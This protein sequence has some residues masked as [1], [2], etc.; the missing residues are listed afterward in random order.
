MNGNGSDVTQ[1]EI[2]KDM[3]GNSS[4]NDSGVMARIFGTFL[5]WRQETKADVFVVA[6]ANN[7]QTLPYEFLRPGRFDATF[8]IDLPT[9]EE[10]DSILAYHMGKSEIDED[11]KDVSKRLD[12]EGWTGAE[13]EQLCYL[14]SEMS[15]TWD[16]ASVRVPVNVK[17]APQSVQ[18]I[19]EFASGWALSA[20]NPGIYYHRPSVNLNLPSRRKVESSVASSE[21]GFEL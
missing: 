14:V 21:A 10:R 11:Y 20:S 15:Y 1:S 16:E 17:R 19:R 2:E 18:Q 13:I 6:T 5:T 7:V 12:L 4:G 3:Q 9:K 8:F